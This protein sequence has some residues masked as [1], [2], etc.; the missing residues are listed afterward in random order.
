MALLPRISPRNDQR[1]QT[2]AYNSVMRYAAKIGGQLFGPVA[3]GQRREFFCLDEHTW[4]WHE[5]WIDTAGHR[6]TVMTYYH[7][8]PD[9]ILKSQGDQTYRRISR[10]ELYN[11]YQAVEL[12][13]QVVP[14]A[15]QQLLHA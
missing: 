3:N 2:E 12:Y 6:Q 7:I 14:P 10:A 5:E 8:R 11:L 9:G 13:E 4:V 15:L 1:R